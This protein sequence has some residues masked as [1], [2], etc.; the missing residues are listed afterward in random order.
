MSRGGRGSRVRNQ[1]WTR[2]RNTYVERRA[3]AD[4][5]LDPDATVMRAHDALRDREA[6]TIALANGPAARVPESVEYVWQF[7]GGNPG[8]SVFDPHGR[9]LILYAGTDGNDSARWSEL[10]GVSHYVPK[11][12]HHSRRVGKHRRKPA[13]LDVQPNSP[14]GRL[15]TE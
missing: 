9:F 12:L 11:C 2:Q 3:D 10:Q 6:E 1:P 5:A 15:L 7:I 14:R 8:S 4:L 13:R